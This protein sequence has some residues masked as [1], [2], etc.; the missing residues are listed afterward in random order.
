VS[1]PI[2]YCAVVGVMNQRVSTQDPDHFTYGIGFQVN[3]PN[4][5]TGRF[6]LM[7]GG[8]TDGSLRNPQVALARNWRKVGL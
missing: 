7:G 1:G 5:W 6:E 2:N 4:T 3:L 8:G